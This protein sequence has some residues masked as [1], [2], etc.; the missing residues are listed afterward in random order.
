MDLLR[1]TDEE[2]PCTANR[3]VQRLRLSGIEAER[4]A[5]LRDV[6]DLQPRDFVDRDLYDH[7]GG[8]VLWLLRHGD[9]VRIL[10]PESIR[11]R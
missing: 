5:V 3:I 8:L 1:G 11:S 6:A 7:G 9:Y 4:K 2:R 10:Q